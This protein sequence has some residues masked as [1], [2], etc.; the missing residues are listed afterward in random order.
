MFKLKYI[1]KRVIIIKGEDL[2]NK[3]LQVAGEL[4]DENGYSNTSVRDIAEK[5]GIGR[6]LL[7]YYFN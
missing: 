3:I 2:K 1:D 6:G 7:Y 5:V 4:F